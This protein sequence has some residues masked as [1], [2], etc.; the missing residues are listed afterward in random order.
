MLVV[1]GCTTDGIVDILWLK[2]DKTGK[3]ATIGFFASHT[4]RNWQ[5]IASKVE[6]N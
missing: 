5:I 3:N 4:L 1:N 2:R 6:Q